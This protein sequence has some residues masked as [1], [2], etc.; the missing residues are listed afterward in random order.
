MSAPPQNIRPG[1]E[2]VMHLSTDATY[3]GDYMLWSVSGSVSYGVPND[4]RDGIMYNAGTKYEPAVEDG[5]NSVYMD[6]YDNPHNPTADVVHEFGEGG[7]PGSE[8]AILF[9]GSSSVTL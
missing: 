1:E 9:Y 2:V 6:P 8:M 5:E 7:A 4:E 3:G